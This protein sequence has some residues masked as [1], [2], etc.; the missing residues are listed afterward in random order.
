[1]TMWLKQST[2]VVV[3]FGPFLDK[4]DGV[5]LETGI[6]A[7]TLDHATTGIMISKNGGTLA[8][9]NGTPTASAYDAHGMYKITLNTTDTGTLGTLRMVFTDAAT[10]L[11]VWQD[12]MVVTANV[13][14][15]MFGADNLQV[16]TVQVGGTAQT[17]RDLGASVLLAADQAVN[18]TKLGG[19]T[20]TA[21]TSVTFPAA[22]T[23]ATTTG[24][25]GSV[26]GDVG[27]NVVGTV[28]SVVTKTGYELS[29]AGI[30]AIWHQ[31]VSAIVTAGTIGKLLVD[32]ITS[33]RMAVLTDWINGGRLDV[34]LDAAATTTELNKVPKSDG[35]T[36]WNATALAAINA[37]VDTA[38]V[39]TTYAEPGQGAPAATARIKDK[40][41]YLY[42]AWRNR[43]NQTATT[44]QLF[45]DDA[46]TVDHK[47]TVSDD[48]TTAEKGEVATGP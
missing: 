47:A 26:T 27:G 29:T 15:S 11:P 35:T 5:T 10:H 19:A 17:A 9:R 3:Q 34:I 39:T 41:G 8:V 4:T 38:L 42:K 12:F 33:V 48:A 30:L 20:V 36:S 6:A 1:M 16:D 31:A 45:N 18:A 7:A 2:S 23:V 32:E 14:D 21:T 24:A 25:V 40:I 37:E 46:V 43:S 28:A 13:W 44:Y 22:S